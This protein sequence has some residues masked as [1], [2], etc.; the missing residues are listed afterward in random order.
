MD[1]LPRAAKGRWPAAARAPREEAAGRGVLVG[2]PAGGEVA[3]LLVVQR[4]AVHVAR[5]AIGRA[6]EAQDGGVVDE[7]VSDGDGLTGRG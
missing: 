3:R 4:G 1:L 7:P 5:L 6:G 2:A